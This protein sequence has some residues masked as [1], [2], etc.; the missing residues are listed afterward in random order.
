MGRSVS[1]PTHAVA[2]VYLNY[3]PDFS[4]LE[5]EEP[6]DDDHQIAWKDFVDCLTW[7]LEGR[8]KSLYRHDG[9]L[10]RED[11]IILRNQH[12]DITVSEYCGC[13]AVCLTPRDD[14]YRIPAI[15]KS[16]CE[17]VATG[18]TAVVEK[19]FPNWAMRSIG[20]ASNGEQFFQP[21][22]RP[23]GVVTSKEGTLW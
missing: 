13:V 6:N 18:F 11:H 7:T 4:H 3:E 21:V 19:A 9:W 22:N 15:A 17:Q 10:D 5:D 23:D 14:D 8:Y 2:K 20:R 12:C 16:W 1:T